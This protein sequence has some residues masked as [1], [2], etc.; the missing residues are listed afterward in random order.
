MAVSPAFPIPGCVV[1]YLEDNQ[2]QT[3]IIL[4]ETGGKL[5]ILLPNR[6]ETKLNASRML[7][8]IGPAY[9]PTLTREEAVKILEK[10]R[11]IRQTKTASIKTL[12]VW[13]VAH[14]EI[15]QAPASWFAE[16]FENDPDMDIY[17]AYG[18]ALLEDKTHFRFTSPD[19]I[20]FDTDTVAAREE[21]QR[22]KAVREA[23]AGQG[24]AFFQL[25]WTIASK[26]KAFPDNFSTLVPEEKLAA[27][28]E[29]L[30]RE[31]MLNP[32]SQLND[33]LWKLLIHGLPEDQFLP[34]Q[35]LQAW[36]KIPPHYN[37]WLDR[38]EY[39]RENWWLD[40]QQEINDILDKARRDKSSG[41]LP[42]V[43]HPYLSIDGEKTRDI[44][45]AFHLEK[46]DSG[47]K[48][49]LAFANPALYWPFGSPLDKKISRR[50]TSLYLPEETL[51]M[52]PADMGVDTF[53]LQAGH[54][55]PA[56]CMTI[57]LDQNGNPVNFEPYLGSIVVTANLRY[58]EVEELL[59]AES[60]TNAASPYGTVLEQASEV[61]RLLENR[62]IQNGAVIML[63]PEL[64]IRLNGE[65]E[66]PH[67]EIEKQP[68]YIDSHRIVSEF[69]I[70]ASASLADWADGK[71]P[72]IHRTQK[73]TL[74]ME[75]AGVWNNEVDLAHIIKAMQPSILEIET[76]PHAALGLAKYAPV[77]SPLRR[78]AD[79]VNEAQVNAFLLDKEP[80]WN[81][82]SLKNMLDSFSPWLESVTQVQK[83]RP[84]YW[85]LI[86]FQQGGDKTWWPAVITEENDSFIFVALPDYGLF[87]R[88]KR[89]LFGERTF[90]GMEIMVRLGK[91]NPLYNE[92]HILETMSA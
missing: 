81:S 85:K 43:L 48:V 86:Y 28:L 26:K 58:R 39:D 69:M 15:T 29:N 51:H 10:H 13:E 7:P 41:A 46:T 70:L 14:D 56:L 12:E 2:V 67:V 6:R 89:E 88:A 44:D 37:F 53:S 74:P 80:A 8:W 36:G 49:H 90:P 32:E 38:A 18:R 92:I 52:L 33:S 57:E 72:L 73:I 60:T 54:A 23:I 65:P 42:A 91:I 55:R 4:E 24:S 20:I 45:D 34:V 64:D 31:R 35:L 30:L 1:E 78:Y 17:S 21:E 63:R 66:N 16:L 84:R 76:A 82:K 11:Q 77:T 61:A 27:T 59:Q 40:H 71:I 47:W 19:F 79:L 50:G 22:K 87:I 62:R 83:F 68:D 25:L 3:G 5:R 75:Y 9:S